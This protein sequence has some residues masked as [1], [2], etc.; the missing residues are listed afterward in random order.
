MEDFELNFELVAGLS[1]AAVDHF[2]DEFIEQAIESQGL[3]FGGG[4]DECISGVVGSGAN[5]Y[6]TME[7]RAWIFNWLKSRKE[8]SFSLYLE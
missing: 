6:I 3:V 4:G 5:D 8:V 7:H 1:P 2:W